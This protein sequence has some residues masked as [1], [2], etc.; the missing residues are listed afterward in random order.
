MKKAMVTG[1]VAALVF[2]VCATG[3]LAAGHHGGYGISGITAAQSVC[4]T[5]ADGN[6]VCGD[7]T[8]RRDTDGDG[9]CDICAEAVTCWNDA[10]GDGVCDV[11]G[12]RHTCRRDADGDGVCDVCGAA[13]GSMA[14]GHHGRGHGHC[15]G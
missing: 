5:D 7:H 2:G 13:C 4:R 8:C 10:G 12:S 1:L 6:T 9:L 11:C 14:G 15:G 3:A